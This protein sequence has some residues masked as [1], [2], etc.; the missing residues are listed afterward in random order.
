MIVVPSCVVW[1]ESESW[2]VCTSAA[3]TPSP[4]IAWATDAD[5]S[6]FLVIAAAAVAARVSTVKE[7]EA[8]SGTV[9]TVPLPETVIVLAAGVSA[10]R[11]RRGCATPAIAEAT[12]STAAMRRAQRSRIMWV[13]RHRP[14]GMSHGCGYAAA[15]DEPRSP[16]YGVQRCGIRGAASLMKSTGWGGLGG[17]FRT[18]PTCSSERSPLRRL[19]GPQAVTTFSQIDSP[20]F[21]RGTTWSRV[22]RPLEVP[23]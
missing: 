9:V 8:R 23:Q 18:I 20:P 14:A 3:G 19:H 15:V 10:D 5:T 6:P 2:L 12:R 4:L 13:I 7:N 1:G 21:E 11:P 17:C 16:R 22:R